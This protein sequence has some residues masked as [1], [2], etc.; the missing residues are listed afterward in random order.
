MRFVGSIGIMIFAFLGAFFAIG[1]RGIAMFFDLPSLIITVI[2]P[3]VFVTLLK[4]FAGLKEAFTIQLNKYATR[5][6]LLKAKLFFKLYRNVT[7]LSCVVAIT[8]GAVNYFANA[9]SVKDMGSNLALALV[10]ILYSALM[11]IAIITPF[12]TYI[13]EKIDQEI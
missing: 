4:G 1:G 12:A 3:I 2:F 11:T 7:W 13:N 5:K 10:S 9:E 8:L 6:M